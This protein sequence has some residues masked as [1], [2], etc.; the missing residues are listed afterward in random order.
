MIEPENLGSVVKFISS[1][2]DY[3]LIIVFEVA[4]LITKYNE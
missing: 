4:E 2:A 1:N 3:S